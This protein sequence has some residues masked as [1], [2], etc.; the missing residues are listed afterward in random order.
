MNVGPRLASTVPDQSG[1]VYDYLHHNNTHT[2]FLAG[3]F[4]TVILVIVKNC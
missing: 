4:E 2:K 3:T 1:S